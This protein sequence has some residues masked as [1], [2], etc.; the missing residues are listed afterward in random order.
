MF[1][2]NSV[3]CSS[4]PSKIAVVDGVSHRQG[5]VLVKVFN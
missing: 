5:E 2:I 3:R 4:E 1:D